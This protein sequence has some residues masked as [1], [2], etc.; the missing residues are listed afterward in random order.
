MTISLLYPHCLQLEENDLY[1]AVNTGLQQTNLGLEN[2]AAMEFPTVVPDKAT[3]PRLPAKPQVSFLH[4]K[5]GLDV[6]PWTVS[7]EESAE[8]RRILCYTGRWLRAWD[9]GFLPQ[10]GP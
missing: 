5:K 1:D 2:P 9:E 7:K 6:S 10:S 3:S 8:V 4:T